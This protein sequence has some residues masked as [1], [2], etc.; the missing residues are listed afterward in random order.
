MYINVVSYFFVYIY[1]ENLIY[2]FFL[3]FWQ[4][5]SRGPSSQNTTTNTSTF[6]TILRPTLAIQQQQPKVHNNTSTL[7]TKEQQRQQQ[8]KQWEAEL[9][10]IVPVSEPN[11]IPTTSTCLGQQQE[12]L[13]IHHSSDPLRSNKVNIVHISNGRI[14]LF[15]KA[16]YLQVATTKPNKRSKLRSF[17]LVQYVEIKNKC[18][19]G[20]WMNEVLNLH[21]LPSFLFRPYLCN[22]E[23]KSI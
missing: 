14:Y 8:Q 12:P 5:V 10:L 1:I 17:I 16:N 19:K 21:F 15:R 20:T 22:E 3:Y 4:K 6:G 13:T 23:R 2:F 18:L 9:D 7:S 11:F